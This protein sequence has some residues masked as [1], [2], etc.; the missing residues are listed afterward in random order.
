MAYDRDP[1]MRS[2][3]PIK[4]FRDAPQLASSLA[5]LL[6]LHLQ[7]LN[8]RP[9]AV[10]LAGGA[11]P[12]DAYALLATR[13]VAV[14]RGAHVLF[15]DDRHVPPE[16]PKSNYGRVLPV[17]RAI[18][19]PM[20]R[21]LRVHGEKPLDEACRAYDS[22]IGAFLNAGGHISLGIL[23]LGTDG[24]TA[25]L[26]SGEHLER[27][28]GH[29]AIAVRRPDGLNGVSVTPDLLARI[30]QI[31]FVVSGAGKRSVLSTLVRD[32]QSLPAG[33]AV[34]GHPNVAIW[35]DGDAC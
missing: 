17:L 13:S 9:T 14:S 1:E 20:E 18:S 11:T 2:M 8:P 19:M 16:S 25:S 30:D 3:F 28:R 7:A 12:M 29:W 23:G 27:A 15:S 21:I 5:D 24:H 31:L 22:A 34:S 32:P 33:M 26:F 10:M 4:T 6:A 35:C